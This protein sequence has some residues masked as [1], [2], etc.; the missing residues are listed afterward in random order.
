MRGLRSLLLAL[1]TLLPVSLPAAEPRIIS[2]LHNPESVLVGP[3][4]RI[5]VSEI[6]EFGRAG[7][8]R[9]RV[10]GADGQMQVFA[11]GLDDPK[12]L[13]IFGNDL[14]VADRARVLRV[15]MDGR[16]SV[17]AAASA[18]PSQPQFLNDLEVDAQGNLYVSDSG[19]LNGRGG[20]IYRIARSGRVEQVVSGVADRRLLAPNGLLMDG[21]SHFLTVDFVSG[22]L[23]RVKLRTGEMEQVAS[24]FGGG[25]GIVRGSGGILY[26]SDWKNGKVFSVNKAGEVKAVAS[27]YQA[28]A[29]LGIT[30]DSAFLLVP[31]MKAGVLHWVPLR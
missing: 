23:Y 28:A 30:R 7:D 20:A 2:G 31:D 5:Y 9:I 1:L 10:L 26:V 8:G 29:D 16:W 11:E 15:G 24:G 25:D 21:S 22:V 19:D 3:D 6:G 13:A 12:G 17:F 4:G 27:G 14:Y 18:F